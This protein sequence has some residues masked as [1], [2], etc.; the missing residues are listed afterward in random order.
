MLKWEL[1]RSLI[2]ELLWS[3]PVAFC[4]G[5]WVRRLL[6]IITIDL[7][8]WGLG[9]V[10]LYQL[11]EFPWVGM[12]LNKSC[13]NHIVCCLNISWVFSLPLTFWQHYWWLS[14]I[15][16]TQYSKFMEPRWPCTS[17][18]PLCCFPWSYITL[19]T[20]SN[21]YISYGPPV[22]KK[23]FFSGFYP[24]L[25]RGTKTIHKFSF[26]LAIIRTLADSNQ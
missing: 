14:F 16:C 10:F 15:M 13:G 1:A 8:L 18:G 5:G 7:L 12:I 22:L 6:I 4:G 26:C 17:S 20:T 9:V 25:K 11:R 23:N 2:V 24:L 19:G 3:S 21:I